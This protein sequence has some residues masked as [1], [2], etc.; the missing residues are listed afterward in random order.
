MLLLRLKL[1]MCSMRIRFECASTTDD[2]GDDDQ[3]LFCF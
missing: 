1:K 3:S 2:D